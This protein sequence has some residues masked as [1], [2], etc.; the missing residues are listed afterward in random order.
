MGLGGIFGPAVK[1]KDERGSSSAIALALS[2]VLTVKGPATIPIPVSTRAWPRDPALE[3]NKG[4]SFLA[5]K[6][7][8]LRPRTTIGEVVDSARTTF[9]PLANV[10]IALRCKTK[11]C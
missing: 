5:W 6:L 9:E 3:P 8:G 4:I 2:C 1:V 10:A 7:R 11:C